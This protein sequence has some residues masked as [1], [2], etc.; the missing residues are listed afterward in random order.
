MVNSY[1]LETLRETAATNRVQIAALISDLARSIDVLTAD[2]Q[3]E[4]AR[5][6]IQEVADPSYSTLAR[7]LRRR[8]ENIGATIASLH[9]CFGT[10]A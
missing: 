7:S 4:E 9:A 2:I 10:A 6:G 3:Q 1:L 8:R 5:A